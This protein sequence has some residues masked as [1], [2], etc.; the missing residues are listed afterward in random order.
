MISRCGDEESNDLNKS[1]E[2]L[3]HEY[4]EKLNNSLNDFN[5][6]NVEYYLRII[7]N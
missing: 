6:D 1:T 7:N 2:E 3:F 5:G 4:E